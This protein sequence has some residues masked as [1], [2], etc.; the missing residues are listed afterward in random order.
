MVTVGDLDLVC[1]GALTI[2]GGLGNDVLNATNAKTGLIR[3]RME[4]NDGDDTL[5]GG[6]G[7]DTL[8]GE[9]GI[10]RLRGGLGN[11]LAIGGVSIDSINGEGGN[12][13][14]FGGDG[15]DTLVGDGSDTISGDEGM[16]DRG[17]VATAGCIFS[18]LA[19][20]RMTSGACS[21]AT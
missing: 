8:V 2:R 19:L 10:D 15:T 21:C 4:G 17:L 12:D 7:N 16:Y 3:M 13:T 18:F 5:I 1:R 9:A 11:D 14:L 6:Q 20:A